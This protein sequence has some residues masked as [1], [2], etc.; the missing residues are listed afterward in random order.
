M[1]WWRIALVL[2]VAP[3]CTR[4]DRRPADRFPPPGSARPVPPEALEVTT[5]PLANRPLGAREL[6]G[7]ERSIQRGGAV[8]V[9][10][11][12][13]NNAAAGTRAEPPVI[14]VDVVGALSGDVK[15]GRRTVIWAPSPFSF[16]LCGN[17]P[18]RGRDQGI[19]LRAPPRGSRAIAQIDGAGRVSW[20]VPDSREARDAIDRG[21]S[22]ASRR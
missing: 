10:E 13:T 6:A 15:P 20:A 19:A 3:A 16:A 18:G 2:V 14:E 5:R 22:L 8:A 17:E 21:R 1:S 9:L 7:I 4:D 12:L 11:V